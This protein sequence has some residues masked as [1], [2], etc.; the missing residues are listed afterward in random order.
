MIEKKSRI[1]NMKPGSKEDYQSLFQTFAKMQQPVILASDKTW[2]PPT[3]VF[4]TDDD[5]VILMD[6]AFIN[7]KDLDITL[8]NEELLIRGIRREATEHKKRHYHKMEIDFGPFESKIKISNS[9]DKNSIKTK[10][11]NGFLEIKLNKISDRRKGERKI[12][13]DWQE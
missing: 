6:I 12:E 2:A 13:I 1:L 9:V 5:Y 3:D 10:Y 11:K 4:E 7:P 8:D